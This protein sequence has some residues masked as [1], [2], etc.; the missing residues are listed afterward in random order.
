MIRSHLCD[1]SDAHIY[2]KGTIAVPNT[3][4]AAAPVNNTNKK[5]MLHLLVV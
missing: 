2:A 4:A 3:A 5:V 1:Y